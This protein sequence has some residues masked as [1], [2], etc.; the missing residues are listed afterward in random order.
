M[1]QL[2]KL[3][4]KNRKV[5][6]DEIKSECFEVARIILYFQDIKVMVR[7]IVRNS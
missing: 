5:S 1:S 3:K 4:Q 6:R 7:T 2:T